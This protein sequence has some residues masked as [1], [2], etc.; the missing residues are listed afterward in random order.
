[1]SLIICYTGTNGSVIIGDKRRIGFFGNEKK[2]ELLEE[3]LYSGSIK[4]Q[5]ALLKRAEELGITL[6]ITDDAE[7]VREI[8]DVIT[9]EVKTTTPFETKRKRIY[10]TTGSYSLVELSGSTIKNMEGGT[11]SM[12]VFGNKYTKEIANKAIQDNWKKKVSL[13]DVG[14]ILEKVMDEVSRQTP[15]VSPNYDL[16]IKHPSLNK[17][18]AR[19]LLRTTILQD[20]KELEKWREELKEQLIKTA[21]GIEMS[22]KILDNGVV[23]KVSKVEGHH[24]EITLAEG[25]EALDLEWNLQAEAGEVVA[26]EVDEPDKIS[27]GDMAVIKDENLCVM[28]SQ[29]G[30]KCEVI[31]CKTDK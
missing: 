21:K 26:M 9:G 16:I 17:K 24:V 19:E 7:K 5:E 8:G 4:T 22:N 13:K 28:P 11:T 27:I 1:M 29:C 6:N 30:L 15:S 3:E 20:V 2:R 23:G 31:L 18:Q 25:V 12:V 10:A 14:D